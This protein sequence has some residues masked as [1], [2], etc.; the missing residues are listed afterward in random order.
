M[1]TFHGSFLIEPGIGVVVPSNTIRRHSI[2]AKEHPETPVF[3]LL[4]SEKGNRRYFKANEHRR[5]RDAESQSG[6]H[7]FV[8][9]RAAA[10]NLLVIEWVAKTCA[11][12]R[13]ATAAEL[14]TIRRDEESRFQREAGA[15]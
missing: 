4:G 14:E 10:G 9:A 15:W 3:Y 2:K 7:L 13:L 5:G 11:G 12:A 6:F 8:P 1:R